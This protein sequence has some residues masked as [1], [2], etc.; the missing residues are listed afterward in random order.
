MTAFVFVAELALLKDCLRELKSLSLFLQSRNAQITE[1]Y[2]RIRITLVAI[3]AIK[4][5]D[6]QS[7]TKFISEFEQNGSFKGI[8]ISSSDKERSDAYSHRQQF[9][10]ALVD[11]LNQRFMEATDVVKSITVLDQTL[12]P[13]EEERLLYGEVEVKK[14][15]KALQLNISLILDLFR[16]L[17]AGHSEGED[18]K[19]FKNDLTCLPIVIFCGKVHFLC[20]G[21]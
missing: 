16:M 3:Q 11:N 1:C 2:T 9:C 4:D 10:Q 12:W 21:P 7:Y 8:Q 5:K 6:G 14:L 19:S 18:F 20:A 17:K 15:S 13:E